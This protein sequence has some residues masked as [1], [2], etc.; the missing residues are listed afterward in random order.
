MTRAAL[1]PT[2]H[3]VTSRGLRLHYVDWG[4]AEAPPLV[5][6]HGGRDHCRS[7]DWIATSLRD[8]WHVVAPDLRGH[9]DSAWSPDSDYSS[10]A[11]LADLVAFVDHLAA[12]P[13][14]LVGHSQGGNIALNYAS[15]FPDKLRKLVSIEGLGLSPQVAAAHAAKPTGELL[16]KWVDGL[17]L[18]ESKPPRRYRTFEEAV[19]RMQNGH[20]RLSRAQ[21]EYLTRHGTRADSD[22]TLRWKFDRRVGIRPAIDLDMKQ[23][24]SL[25]CNIT[26]PTLLVYGT[27]SWASNPAADGRAGYFPDAR[28]VLIEGAGH[29]VHQDQPETL[30]AAMDGFL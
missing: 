29:W 3:T 6:I 8:R 18:I 1:E 19:E 2:S 5:L 14:T 27:E 21:A 25:W 16:R 4:N 15:A 13:A 28:V 12:G 20:P 26:C 10:L 9:G 24:Q 11:Y 23:L 7:W 22:G 30:V 17:R